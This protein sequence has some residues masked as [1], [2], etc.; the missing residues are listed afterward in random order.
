MRLYRK[1]TLVFESSVFNA[2]VFLMGLIG[3]ASLAAHSIAIQI[4]SL[5]FMIPLGIAQAAS[6]RVG[7][8]FGA[9]DGVAARR[10]GWIAYALGVG[11]MVVTALLMVTVPRAMISVFLD[12][13]APSNA[14]VAALAT[15]FLAMA[16]LFQIV[17][18]AQAVGSGMLRGLHDTRVPMIYA[19]IGYWGVGMPVGVVLAFHLGWGGVGIWS[20]LALALAVVAALMLG[21]WI[22]LS[23]RL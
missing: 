17:D 9:R 1:P 21:R 10:A 2:A 5:A 23:R 20:G 19:L 13:E 12:V 15:T 6:V 8:A 16:A 18:G 7:R 14:E 22:R 4:A 3:A 11:T